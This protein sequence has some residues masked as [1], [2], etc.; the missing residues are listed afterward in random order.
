MI[1]TSN[2][3]H[4]IKSSVAKHELPGLDRTWNTP[5]PENL[6]HSL[7]SW[8]GSEIHW[9]RT[10]GKYRRASFEAHINTAFIEETF[11]ISKLKQTYIITVRQMILS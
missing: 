4:Q 8:H 2:D 10:V 11:N 1:A 5:E 6:K 3:Q 9:R 7:K